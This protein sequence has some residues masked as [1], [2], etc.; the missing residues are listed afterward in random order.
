[1]DLKSCF[2]FILSEH[3]ISFAQ[4]YI[5]HF[6]LMTVKHSTFLSQEIFHVRAIKGYMKGSEFFSCSPNRLGPPLLLCETLS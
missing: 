2:N 6:I 5:F 3:V 1:M 4:S